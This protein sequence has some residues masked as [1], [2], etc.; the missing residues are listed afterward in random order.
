MDAPLRA[1]DAPRPLTEVRYAQAGQAQL[2]EVVHAQARRRHYFGSD[3]VLRVMGGYA[4]RAGD[5]L[6]PNQ[7]LTRGRTLLGR[8]GFFAAGGSVEALVTHARGTYGASGGV[9]P[10]DPADPA[11]LYDVFRSAPRDAAAR[12]FSY[13]TDL[14]L[15]GTRGG[16]RLAVVGAWEGL[17]YGRAPG[18]TT[19]GRVRRMGVQA[20]GEVAPLGVRVASEAFVDQGAGALAGTAVSARVVLARRLGPAELQV[21]EAWLEGRAYPVAH[22]AVQAGAGPLRFEAEGGADALP[23]SAVRRSGFGPY[24]EA[25]REASLQTLYA[26]AGAVLHAG[27]ALVRAHAFVQHD[28]T[29]E[30]TGAPGRDT[31]GA[32]V[33]SALFRPGVMAEARF[34]DAARRGLYAQAWAVLRPAPRC[35]GP[36]PEPARRLR[37]RPHRP[38]RQPLPARPRARRLRPRA[39]VDGLCEPERPRAHGPARAQRRRRT[40]PPRPPS[41]SSPKRACA[42]PRSP[43]PT[44]MPS[45]ARAC[46]RACRCC[47]AT[48]FPRSAFVSASSGPSSIEA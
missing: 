25:P 41:T 23:P 32:A 33:A 26:R 4:G 47:P 48:R 11:S 7:R 8:A 3:G 1:F 6:F 35:V 37:R 2:A 36:R 42:R 34:R 12:R 22:A 15:I 28:G 10:A 39:R 29:P 31:L 17:E 13:R 21:G 44:T 16:A 43:S 9:V 27:A 46:S 30:W 19:R 20:G 38:P 40:C 14:A 18:D 5:G 24:L 45:P